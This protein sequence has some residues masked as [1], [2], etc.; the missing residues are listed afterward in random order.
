M[1]TFK[2]WSESQKFNISSNKSKQKKNYMWSASKQKQSMTIKDR[3]YMYDYL[4]HVS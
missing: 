1:S 3:L 4:V 2:F